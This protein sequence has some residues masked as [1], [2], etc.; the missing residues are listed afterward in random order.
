MTTTTA[1]VLLE[2]AARAGPQHR[3]CLLADF[4]VEAADLRFLS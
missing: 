4:T 1:D 2:L 3:L